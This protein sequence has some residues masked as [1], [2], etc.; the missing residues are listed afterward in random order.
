[1]SEESPQPQAADAPLP[2]DSSRDL[3]DTSNANASNSKDL[4]TPSLLQNDVAAAAKALEEVASA[5][6]QSTLR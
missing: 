3:V 1:M 2:I 6:G 4:Q 5:G